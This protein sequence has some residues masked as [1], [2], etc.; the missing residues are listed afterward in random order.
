MVAGIVGVVVD[1][2]VVGMAGGMAGGLA[3]GTGN[4]AVSILFRCR[5]LGSTPTFGN[6]EAVKSPRG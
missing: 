4:M 2:I 6:F 1:G 5:R 3:G